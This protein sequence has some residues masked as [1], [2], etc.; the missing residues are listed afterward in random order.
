MMGES[1]IMKSVLENK[2]LYSRYLCS[3]IGLL[4]I[5]E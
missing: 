1:V 2:Q 3:V 4:A 5:W